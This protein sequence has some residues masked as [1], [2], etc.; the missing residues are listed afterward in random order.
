MD[1][2]VVA[3]EDTV[4]GFRYVGIP[5]VVVADAEQAAAELDRL[6]RSQAELIVITTEQIADTVRE[7]VSAIRFLVPSGAEG[8]EAL[9]LIVEIPGPQGPSEKS[10]SL[11]KMIRE[12]VGI[13]F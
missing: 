2:Y 10:P 11:M 5:G 9:P 3:D 7:K 1:F 13:R 8:R 6:A 4:A 12:A